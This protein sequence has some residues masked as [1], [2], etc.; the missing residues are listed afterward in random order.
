MVFNKRCLFFL[1]I[2]SCS[3]IAETK[4]EFIPLMT[5]EEKEVCYKNTEKAEQRYLIKV[6]TKIGF[7]DGCGR[8][9][10][11]PIY[12]S[13]L[14]FS[15]GLAR[16]EKDNK[17]GFIDKSGEVAVDFYLDFAW[18]FSEGL[19]VA[20]INS[21]DK[22]VFYVDKLNNHYFENRF[23]QVSSFSKGLAFAENGAVLIDKKGEIIEKDEFVKFKK[24][25]NNLVFKET[26]FR[27]ESHGFVLGRGLDKLPSQQRKVFYTDYSGQKQGYNDILAME[28]VPNCQG[29]ALEEKNNS[30]L[31]QK[32]GEIIKT[33]K[34]HKIYESPICK[35][36]VVNI[37]WIKKLDKISLFE[38]YYSIFKELIGFR[39][40]EI[41]NKYI[42]ELYNLD[43]T[44][45][46]EFENEENIEKVNYLRE[47]AIEIFFKNGK[48]SEIFNLT[49]NIYNFAEHQKE[50]KMLSGKLCDDI[51]RAEKRGELLS[52]GDRTKS[53]IC[54]NI[55][56][57]RREKRIEGQLS[58]ELYDLNKKKIVFMGQV[59]FFSKYESLG[60]GCVVVVV[61]KNKIYYLNEDF[62]I[63]WEKQR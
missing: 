35:N 17:F 29:V 55:K 56:I 31:F 3:L 15:E 12:D 37:V 8:M 54:N 53:E 40:S 59:S 45:I 63:F 44:R 39:K 60:Q 4:E 34:N 57:E 11:E 48:K 9:I 25:F 51:C 46:A 42:L 32:N 43:G 38:E 13:A 2:F 23:N 24:S 41:A 27:K 58:T 22:K 14:E 49:E 6:D 19:A 5:K 26:A 50:E 16:V 62:K 10:I 18:F 1:L 30:V 52:L 20:E 36:G 7:V 33:L 47:D 61:A 21:S 28:L